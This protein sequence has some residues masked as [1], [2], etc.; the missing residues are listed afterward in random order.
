[1]AYRESILSANIAV[2]RGVRPNPFVV[3]ANF[4]FDRTGERPTG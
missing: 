1:M 2:P 3:L 4:T